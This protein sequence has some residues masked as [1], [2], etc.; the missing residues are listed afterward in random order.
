MPT[1][2]EL[3]LKIAAINRAFWRS[4]D[5]V[6]LKLSVY[7]HQEVS[8]NNW[9]AMCQLKTCKLSIVSDISLFLQKNE[10]QKWKTKQKQN[11]QKQKQKVLRKDSK[12]LD[13]SR[14]YTYECENLTTTKG[15]GYHPLTV[16]LR[17]H[18][19]AKESD[20]GHLGHLFYIL[21][22]HFDEKPGGTPRRWG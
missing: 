2:S 18:K 13:R 7:M 1:V 16:C 9:L 17:P 6:W 8:I 4:F 21:C 12:H 10:V 20:P 5:K 22:G 14:V 15:G 3:A 11:K 19:N